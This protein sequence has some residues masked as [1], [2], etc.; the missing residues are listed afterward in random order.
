MPAHRREDHESWTSGGRVVERRARDLTSEAH[1]YSPTEMQIDQ[2]FANKMVDAAIADCADERLAGDVQKVRKAIL[3]GECEYCG[4]IAAHL[5]RPIGEYLMQVDNTV[6]A[7]YQYQPSEASAKAGR[8]N[9]IHFL[10]WVEHKSAALNA[11]AGTLESALVDS[12][13][14]LGCPN[15]GPDC[16]NLDMEVVDDRDVREQRGL[17]LLVATS[18]LQAQ[19][20]CDRKT[21]PEAVGAAQ[22]PATGE[23]GYELPDWLDPELIPEERLIQHALSI[24]EL[25]PESRRPLEHHLTELKVTLIRRII[26]D[27]L[28]YI[29]I[30]KRWLSVADLQDFY[31]RRIGFGRIGGKSAGMLLAERILRQVASEELKGS[32]RIPDSYFLGSDLMYIFMSM[33]GLMHWNNQ[34]YKAEE[35][36]RAEYPQ[37]QKEFTAGKF[38]PEILIELEGLLQRFRG[39]P[40]IVR[41]SSQLEDNL[42]TSFAG[43]YDSNFCPNQGTPKANLAALTHAIASTYAST[44]KPDALLYRRSKGLQDYDE[45]MAVLIQPVVGERAG[46][47]YFPFAAGVA[48]SRN[49][50]RWAPQIRRET[51]FLRMVWGLGTR[52]VERVGNDYCHVVALS[53]PTLQPDDAPEAIRHYSQHYVDVIDI[54]GNALKTLPVQEVLKPTYAPIRYLVQLE[55]DG[56]LSTPLMRLTQSDIPRAAITFDKTLKGTP[57]AGLMTELLALLQENYQT[58]VDVEFTLQLPD[59]S[60]SPPVV[61]IS[62]L[63]CRPLSGLPEAGA[64]PRA[65]AIPAEDIIFSTNYLVPNGYLSDIRYVIFVSPAEYFALPTA[66]ARHEIG[67]LISQLNRSLPAK[68][69]ICV[70]PGR[71]GTENIDLGVYVGY[72]DIC[73]AAALVELAGG[74]YGAGPEPSLGTHFFQDLME[75][76]IYPLAVSVDHKGTVFDAD[77]FHK[78]PNSLDSF[79]KTTPEVAGCLRLIDLRSYRPNH[80]LELIMDDEEGAAVAFVT[81]DR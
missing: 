20:V 41:S 51:G 79:L 23:T 77:F 19:V 34:K 55:R 16:L 46:D 22:T 43:K 30:A 47:Y 26:S 69:F 40:I 48:F 62:L 6:R 76:R 71:W 60:A 58:A 29:E 33:N 32:L 11:L 67:R 42:G 68:S 10:V 5:V 1:R 53:H 45:R 13:R 4:C 66:A 80:H 61:T 28:R 37:I 81:P 2:S 56:Y 17:G 78:S 14:K 12:Q 25:P 75:A 65:D 63:Q 54:K 36:I 15:A 50:Y 27:Q 38:P 57:F 59:P 7:V 18:A 21:P 9:H 73:N 49:M 64:V 70:G 74:G 72:P 8:R 52:A 3:H 44:F 39:H 35:Q 31:R 24:E